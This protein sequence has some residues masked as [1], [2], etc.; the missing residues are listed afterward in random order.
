MF[1]NIEACSRL[2]LMLGGRPGDGFAGV[3][4]VGGIGRGERPLHLGRHAGRTRF[5]CWGGGVAA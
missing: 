3:D 2:R 5:G 1:G 4:A